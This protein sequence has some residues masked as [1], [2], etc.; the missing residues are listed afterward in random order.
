VICH[1]Q[2]IT[3]HQRELVSI[4]EQWP[5]YYEAIPNEGRH[6]F[7]AQKKQQQWQ[8]IRLRLTA[9]TNWVYAGSGKYAR[10]VPLSITT[11]PPVVVI[12]KDAAVVMFF[13][14]TAMFCMPTL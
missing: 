1:N 2:T 13:P 5:N 6:E 10:V 4:Q 11:P 8:F 14:L 7:R 12:S 9:S 3:A